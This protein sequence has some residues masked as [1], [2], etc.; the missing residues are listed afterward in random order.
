MNQILNVEHLHFSFDAHPIL[1]DVS[2][3]VQS[4]SLMILSGRNGSGK[5]VLLRCLKGL[6]PIHRGTITLGNNDVSRKPALRNQRIALV[7]QDADTQ[8][9][10][11]TVQKDIL[12]GLENLGV[13]TAEQQRRLAETVQLLH[14]QDLLHHRPR[15]LSGGER[16]R[17]AIAGVLVMKPEILLLDEPFANLDYPGIVSVLEA[18]IALHQGGATIVIATHEIEKILAHA[19][20]LVVLDQGSIV[21]SGNPSQVIEGVSQYGIRRPMYHNR[22]IAVEELTWLK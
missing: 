7:F 8:V 6:Y 20:D 17:L 18:L 11:Q 14:L 13:D 10:G 15:T 4:G 21:L 1:S 22:P 5:S 16:R 2:F 19:T 9:V 3:T 12:F